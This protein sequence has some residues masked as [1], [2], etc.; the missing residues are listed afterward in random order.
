MYSETGTAI[1]AKYNEPS[2]RTGVIEIPDVDMT[3]EE[4]ELCV[5]VIQ[6]I[7]RTVQAARKAGKYGPYSWIKETPEHQLFRAVR[8]MNGELARRGL[9]GEVLVNP[10]E[11][12]LDHAVCR[13]AILLALEERKSGAQG[14]LMPFDPVEYVTKD[15][16]TEGM[17]AVA[18]ATGK[19]L[20]RAMN[21]AAAKNLEGSPP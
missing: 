11:P 14:I 2:K 19:D 21:D 6:A 16:M 12:D 18:E 17:K 8:H 20:A 5:P 1:R 13:L 10:E 9:S 3:M 4:I 15:G 7:M